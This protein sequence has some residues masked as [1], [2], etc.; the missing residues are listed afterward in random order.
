M[1]DLPQSS[2]TLY[3]SNNEY[4][5]LMNS[6]KYQ[7][8]KFQQELE[9]LMKHLWYETKNGHMVIIK[10]RGEHGENNWTVSKKKYK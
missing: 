7:E 4:I 1:T 5:L 2:W 10:S 8:K 9:K 6:V 3:D